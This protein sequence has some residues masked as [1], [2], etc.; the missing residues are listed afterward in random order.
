MRLREWLTSIKLTEWLASYKGLFVGLLIAGLALVALGTDRDWPIV[1]TIGGT[2]FGSSIAQLLGRLTNQA[3]EER[4]NK[5]V[6]E[7]VKD[8]FVSDEEKLENSRIEW[9]LYH[10]TQM[11]D[12]VVWRHTILD[13][14]KSQTPGRLTSMT[15]LLDKNKNPQPYTVEAGRRDERFIVILRSTRDEESAATYV[16]PYMGFKPSDPHYGVC[17]LETWDDTRAITPTILSQ[18]ALHRH[19]SKQPGHPYGTLPPAT[20]RL[21]DRE[22]RREIHE[23]CSFFP[24][25]GATTK[26]ASLG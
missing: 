12:E 5:L 13:F 20:T 25:A 3:S 17:F 8:S 10:V 14:T 16:F 19:G 22:W 9:Q 11:D 1:A 6:R 2:L 21:L 26:S 24:E 23:L 4:I 15:Y 7:G 18:K